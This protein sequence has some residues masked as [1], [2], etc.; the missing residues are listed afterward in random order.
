MVHGAAAGRQDDALCVQQHKFKLV[1]LVELLDDAPQ[2]IGAAFGGGCGVPRRARGLQAA[3]DGGKTIF[4]RALDT[5]VEVVVAVVQEQSLR[6]H[7]HQ[8]RDQQAAAYPAADN[9]GGLHGG[10]LLSCGI[11]VGGERAG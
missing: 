8:H 3:H 5:A 7:E 10:E 1:L 9:A 2:D 11:L 4:H 6:Q